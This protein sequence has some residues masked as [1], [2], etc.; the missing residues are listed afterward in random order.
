MHDKSHAGGRKN[1]NAPLKADP[2]GFLS[3]SLS[4]ATSAVQAHQNCVCVLGRLSRYR[5]LLAQVFRDWSALKL[6]RLLDLSAAFADWRRALSA[7]LVEALLEES[8]LIMSG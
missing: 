5:G 3:V 8:L 6:E 7:A 4:I 2:G 1:V